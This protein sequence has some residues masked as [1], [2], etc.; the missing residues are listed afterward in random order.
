MRGE[1]HDTMALLNPE[2]AK[3]DKAGRMIPLLQ[4]KVKQLAHQ[5]NGLSQENAKL[6]A[7]LNRLNKLSI[8]GNTIEADI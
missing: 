7:E 3:S 6:R 5:V 4:N 8:N 1:M 2:A